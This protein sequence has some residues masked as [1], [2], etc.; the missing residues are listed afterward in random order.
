[1]NF[2]DRTVELFKNCDYYTGEKIG[3]D[4]SGQQL[5]YK[6]FFFFSLKKVATYALMPDMANCKTKA[7]ENFTH[8]NMRDMMKQLDF[9]CKQDGK[10]FVYCY[11]YDLDNAMHMNGVKSFKA[12]SV[13]RSFNKKIEKLILNN[14]STLAVITAD[15][16]HID[17]KGRVEI[18][19]DEEIISCLASNLSLEPRAACFNIKPGF[20]QKF[21]NAFQKYSADFELFETKELIER[22]VFGTF[23][24]DKHKQFLGNFIAIGKDTN[25]M[26]IFAENKGRKHGKILR[27]HHTGA[28]ETEMY[29]PLILVSSGV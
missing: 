16:G 13:I 11:N 6:K 25:K 2:G 12:K 27:G 28:T 7:Q 9:V 18:Y 10:K 21:R 4:F 22:N 20:E 23:K 29:V 8:K 26:L 24:G 1:M 15:H 14:P 5:P 19:K 17:L 3:Y